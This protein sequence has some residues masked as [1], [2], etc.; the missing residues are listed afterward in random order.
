M[1]WM[2]L[3]WGDDRANKLRERFEIM[4]IPALII[5]D[6]ETGFTVTPSALKDLDK[7]VKEVYESWAKLLELRKDNAVLRAEQDALAKAQRAEREWL[8]QQQKEAAERPADTA[9]GQVQ[10]EVA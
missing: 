2:T 3:P 10:A 5:L 4:G 6:A 7:D 1:P 9:T 8:I